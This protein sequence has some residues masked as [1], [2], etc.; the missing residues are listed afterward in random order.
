[1]AGRLF[2]GTQFGVAAIWDMGGR[3]LLKI[4]LHAVAG[5]G[6]SISFLP[7]SREVLLNGDTGLMFVNL[8]DGSARK[9]RDGAPNDDYRLSRDGR[10]LQIQHPVFDADIWLMEFAKPGR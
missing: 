10:T 6:N 9:I 7:D 8:V 4:D 3:S 1:M 5:D 2:T